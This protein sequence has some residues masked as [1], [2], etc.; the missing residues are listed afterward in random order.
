MDEDSLR[1]RNNGTAEEDCAV[2]FHN[3]LLVKGYQGLSLIGDVTMGE[4]GKKSQ[5]ELGVNLPVCLG[6]GPPGFEF[7]HSLL[8]HRRLPT[9]NLCATRS[10][11]PENAAKW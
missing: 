3:S 4:L 6:Y 10:R 7:E 5:R 9:S 2:L 8:V 11:T 1:G